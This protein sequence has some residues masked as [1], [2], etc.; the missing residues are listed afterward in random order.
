MKGRL[1]AFEGMNVLA[2]LMCGTISYVSHLER[3]KTS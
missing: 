1:L 3:G 2:T